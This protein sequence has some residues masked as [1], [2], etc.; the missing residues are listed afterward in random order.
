M[1]KEPKESPRRAAAKTEPSVETVADPVAPESAPYAASPAE[2]A[3]DVFGAFRQGQTDA[4]AAAERT[5]PVIKKSLAKG[6][7]MFCY[8]L[9]F[10]AVYSAEVAMG[11]VPV[12]SVIRQGM[13]D[14]ANA[15]KQT[16]SNRKSAK[17]ATIEGNLAQA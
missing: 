4:V 5:L 17:D 1:S 10:G 6:T 2:T 8:Y 12:D 15:A 14:G 9:A 3:D 13:R 16:Y 7:Y 11:L